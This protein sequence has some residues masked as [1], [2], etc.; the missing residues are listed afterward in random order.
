MTKKFQTSSLPNLIFLVLLFCL[1][2]SWVWRL[3][4]AGQELTYSQVRQLILQ[5]KVE[6]IAVQDN[7]LTMR[8]REEVDGMT[9]VRY[10]LYDF[11]YFIRDLGEAIEDQESRG[12]ILSY[13]YHKDHSTKWAELLLPMLLV[14]FAVAYTLVLALLGEKWLVCV[15]FLRIMCISYCFWP[16]HITNLQA[17]NALGRSDIFLKLEIVKKVLIGLYCI[18]KCDI[19]FSVKNT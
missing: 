19:I 14:L 16:I 9:T 3:N 2:L 15:P 13:D 5:E 18:E 7:T 1:C 6:T 12:I 8:L 11:D 17:I 4:G 10:E